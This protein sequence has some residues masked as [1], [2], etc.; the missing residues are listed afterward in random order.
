VTPAVVVNATDPP[1]MAPIP[2]G[3]GPD[4]DDDDDDDDY[5]TAGKVIV[6]LYSV[7]GQMSP[8]YQQKFE[9]DLVL[10]YT[11][12]PPDTFH[13]Y[14]NWTAELIQQ[15][16]QQLERKRR[17]GKEAMCKPFCFRWKR[18]PSLPPGSRAVLIT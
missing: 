6:V 14:S 8:N 10:F 16:L 17:L 15:E 7:D 5:I 4:D 3:D 12:N 2:G 9:N 1:T 18:Y 13:V 11:D